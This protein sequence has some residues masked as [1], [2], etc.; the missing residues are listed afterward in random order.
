MN[1]SP[2]DTSTR[3]PLRAFAAVRDE[4]RELRE[5][6]RQYRALE[7][8][9]ATYTTRSDVDDLMAALDREGGP[10]ADQIREILN[11]NVT[12]RRT[13]QLAS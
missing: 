1:T 2:S 9:L 10:E 4:L 3:R 8:E 5:A 13:H 7:R 6:R 11:R 12:P